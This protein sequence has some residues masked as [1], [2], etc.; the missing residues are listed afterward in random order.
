[1]VTKSAGVADGDEWL[2][3]NGLKIEEGLPRW[4]G[5]AVCGGTSS[6][7][8]SCSHSHDSRKRMMPAVSA[9]QADTVAVAGALPMCNAPIGG[10]TSRRM[11]IPMGKPNRW[12][13]HGAAGDAG[14][15]EESMNNTVNLE[16]CTKG[17]NPQS[18]LRGHTNHSVGL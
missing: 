10:T 16:T 7:T 2:E 1:M 4:A 12:S 3:K 8:V 11:S 9:L 18:R 13:T 14:S 17:H 5:G 15:G 6:H